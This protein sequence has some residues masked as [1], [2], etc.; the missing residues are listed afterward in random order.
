MEGGGTKSPS[1][2][3]AM[4][5]ETPHLKA[6]VRTTGVGKAALPAAA[7][8]GMTGAVHELFCNIFALHF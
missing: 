4:Q 3:L 6:G 2:R 1:I 8:P 5:E 7:P